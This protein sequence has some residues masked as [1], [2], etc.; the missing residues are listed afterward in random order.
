[1]KSYDCYNA[2]ILLKDKE[3]QCIAF[4]TRHNKYLK[5][6]LCEL[7]YTM[8]DVRHSDNDFSKPVSLEKNV[9]VN[10]WGYLAVNKNVVVNEI[11][12]NIEQ[13]GLFKLDGILNIDYNTLM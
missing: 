12:K 11:A 3:I 1:M 13:Y 7:G 8:F 4:E 2:N 10:F 9:T 6:K 5:Q